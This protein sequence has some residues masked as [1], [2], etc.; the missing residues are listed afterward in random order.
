M[1]PLRVALPI[2]VFE[3]AID[4]LDDEVSLKKTSLVCRAWLPRSRLNLFRVI[5]LSLPTHLDRFATLLADAPHIAPCVEEIDISE[6]SFLGLFR[7]ELVIVARL[8]SVLAAHPLIRPRRLRVFDQLWMPT[9]YN[10]DY[11]VSLSQ[12]SSIT[13]LDIHDVTFTTVADFSIILRALSSSL[14]FL[15]AKH[16][17]C[18][19]PMDASIVGDIGC[20]LPFLSTLRASSKHPTSPMDWLL[21]SN[22]FPALRDA[23]CTYEL[24]TR[25]D[26]QTLGVFWVSVG[27]TLEHLSLSISK[28]A[29]GTRFPINVIERQLALSHCRTLRTLRLDCRNERGIIPDWTWL[30]W[31]LPHLTCDTLR[32]I[33]FT[34]QSASHA[35]ASMHMFFEELDQILTSPPFM[36]SLERAIFEFDY[37]DKAHPD[38]RRFK[39]LFPG[40]RSRSMLQ[41]L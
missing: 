1:P 41:V 10:P 21:G 33:T 6:N 29:T 4:L 22:S 26:G 35:L 8:P 38:D 3:H 23:E 30:A 11:L 28:R 19:R 20:T 27:A 14:T 12:L 15:S 13:S 24:S 37:R 36:G 18:Q 9:R 16:L 25:D 5:Q 40:L 17:D 39:E 2:E 32:T 34:F 31:L 7:P